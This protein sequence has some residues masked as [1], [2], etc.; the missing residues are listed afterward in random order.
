MELMDD[1]N[2]FMALGEAPTSNFQR[3]LFNSNEASVTEFQ[4]S[5]IRIPHSE[6]T[7]I[8]TS[9]SYLSFD[10]VHD[11]VGTGLNSGDGVHF[12]ASGASAYISS[13]QVYQNGRL[14]NDF[15]SYDKI[16]AMLNA[17]N[18]G[19]GNRSGGSVSQGLPTD[20]RNTGDGLIIGQSGAATT[21]QYVGEYSLNLLGIMGDVSKNLPLGLMTGDVEIVVR[22][23][24]PTNAIYTN[25]KAADQTIST[26]L[27]SY[28]ASNI[29]YNAKVITVSPQ[30]NEAIKRNSMDDQGIMSWSSIMCRMD[31]QFNIPAAVLS[32][33][34]NLSNILAGFRYASLRSI[35]ACG[36]NTNNND[37]SNCKTSPYI[38]MNNRD[39]IQYSIGGVYFPQ[40]PINGSSQIS[41]ET[42]INFSS[43]SQAGVNNSFSNGLVGYSRRMLDGADD[44][45][46]TQKSRGVSIVN[47]QDSYISGNAGLNTKAIQV[48]ANSNISP[49]AEQTANTYNMTAMFFPFFDCIYSINKEGYLSSSW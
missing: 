45:I 35:A 43:S 16:C 14:V 27:T 34:T 39:A 32:T 9:A 10:V 6:N 28:V 37:N 5:R 13:L 48:V 1:R 30:E 22:W 26:S 17:S 25:A 44:N 42:N 33:D 23:A 41:A 18:V 40:I 12:S 19:Y 24:G 3:I 20:N 11:I 31:S 8:D 47:L 21:K 29:N 15:P 46:T 4:E 49:I 7:Y 2:V 36:F 38:Y